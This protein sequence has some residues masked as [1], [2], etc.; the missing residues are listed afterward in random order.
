MYELK[1]VTKKFE[2]QVLFKNVNLKIQNSGLY[3]I[4]G[5]SGTGKTTLLNVLKE[6][7]DITSGE[8]ITDDNIMIGNVY[9]DILL[10]PYYTVYDNLLISLDNSSLDKKEK[11]NEIVKY[12]KLFQLEY[13]LNSK[14][15]E[16]SGGE[17][18]RVAII[19]ALLNNTNV[20][21]CDEPTAY[22]DLEN[23]KAIFKMFKE[24]SKEKLVIVVTHNI[25]LAYEYADH[26]LEIID[27]DINHTVLNNIEDS[28]INRNYEKNQ[29]KTSNIIN[30]IFTNIRSMKKIYIIK[31]ICVLFM[32]ISM[33]MGYILVNQSNVIASSTIADFNGYD[34]L[35]FNNNTSKMTTYTIADILNICK[36][37]D[38]II[39][40]RFDLAED[41]PFGVGVN[42][43]NIKVEGDDAHSWW[44]YP[45]SETVYF[46]N[47]GFNGEDYSIAEGY[48]YEM[49]DMSRFDLICGS[50]SFS[51]K[52][53]AVISVNIA[54][55][56]L[57]RYSLNSYE[58]LINKDIE[59]YTLTNGMYESYNMPMT[60]KIIGVVNYNNSKYK[61][62]FMAPYSYS[63]LLIETYDFNTD[64][65]SWY[66]VEFILDS[67]VDTVEKRDQL[68]EKIKN[69]YPEAH[70][71]FNDEVVSIS[72]IEILSSI[73]SYIFCAIIICVIIISL[74]I[75]SYILWNEHET[76]QIE[77]NI[78]LEVGWTL[79]DIVIQNI[80]TNLLITFISFVFSIPI[81]YYI[82]QKMNQ[83]IMTISHHLDMQGFVHLFTFDATFFCIVSIS[84]FILLSV[85]ELYF[86]RKE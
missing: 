69:I 74:L 83:L 40:Y 31:L 73:N 46:C 67:S 21:L 28:H 63:Q 42:D 71:T 34:T 56:L 2:S 5:K 13:L 3:V 82:F 57:K 43:P 86:E 72:S 47:D 45:Y 85:F 62:I 60:V 32:I 33:V 9:Q 38:S 70:F 52:T 12:L 7:E 55:Y 61:K 79:K 4:I 65:M 48:V 37:D 29:I 16:L 64:D 81:S 78:K 35:L 59:L 53:D 17:K 24:I 25:N 41:W 15:S 66:N 6:K 19:R 39:G 80:M 84:I 36:L 44:H 30:N 68:N 1:N 54:D 14:I 26:I 51:N 20:L 76:R 11:K 23:S 27:K 58:E 50:Q 22:L 10:I 49:R 75:L 8:L 18:Q 77:K